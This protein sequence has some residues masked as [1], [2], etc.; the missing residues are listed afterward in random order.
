MYCHD[1]VTKFDSQYPEH[2]WE[3]SEKQIYNMILQV[4]DSSNSGR[5]C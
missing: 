4:G 5:I 1:F 3:E 2:P